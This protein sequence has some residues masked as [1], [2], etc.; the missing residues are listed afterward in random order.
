MSNKIVMAWQMSFSNWTI[1]LVA[2]KPALIFENY[3]E[4]VWVSKLLVEWTRQ[5]WLPSPKLISLRIRERG[6][7][8]VGVAALK[9]VVTP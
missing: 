6:T 3:G 1:R 9:G 7:H 4:R 8:Y 2:S 5:R